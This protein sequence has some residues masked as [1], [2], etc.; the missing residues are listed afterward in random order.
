MSQAKSHIRRLIAGL[1]AK[2]IKPGDC[3]LINAMNDIYFMVL[4]L[5]IIGCGGI[6]A[7]SNPAYTPFETAHHMRITDTQWVMTEP[8]FLQNVLEANKS[9]GIPDSNVMI[10]HPLPSQTCPPGFLSWTTLLT[11]GEADWIRFDDYQRCKTTTAARLTSSGTSGLPKAT[12]NTHLN[13]IAQHEYNFSPQFYYPPYA[14]INIF[15]LP[16]FHAAIVPRTLTSAWKL[17]ETNYIMRR[18]EPTAF[19]KSIPRFGVT[20]LYLVP[21]L[22]IALIMH[23]LVQSNEVSLRSVRSGWVGAAPLTRDTQQRLVQKLSPGALFTQV[24]G[25]TESN[26]LAS[27]FPQN[28]GDDTG[29]VGYLCAGMEG[30]LVDAEGR[31]ISDWGVRGEMC[32]RGESVIPGYHNNETANQKS[33]DA[34]GFYHS[35]DVMYA[36]KA[37]GKLYVVDRVKELIKVRGFQVAP[38]EVESVLLE[39]PALVD[40]AV[41][42]VKDAQAAGESELCRAYVVVRPGLQK[43]EQPS[44][45]DVYDWVKKRLVRYKHLD[46]GVVFV[47]QIPKT[48]SGKILKRMLRDEFERQQKASKL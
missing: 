30:K 13:L 11:H 45:Q 28:E 18:F 41:I 25:M 16:M 26:C 40:A 15:P 7:G 33:W 35:G 9:V 46:G 38:P 3:V 4:A 47:D 1:R 8:E 32:V 12:N 10:F 42:G 48:A 19:I 2:G 21:P 29:S 31:D 24:W 23:P 36:D 17:G 22:V 14:T 44:A 34:D 43:A 6:F 37:T 20:D 5:A 39:M 27:R